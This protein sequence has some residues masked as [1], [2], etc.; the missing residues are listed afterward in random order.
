MARK[1]K[2]KTYAELVKISEQAVARKNAEYA[3]DPSMIERGTKE[4]LDSAIEEIANKVDVTN[5]TP[6]MFRLDNAASRAVIAGIGA[7]INSL[8]VTVTR[9]ADQANI[10]VEDPPVT[11][12]VDIDTIL[13]AINNSRGAEAAENYIKRLIEEDNARKNPPVSEE[14]KPAIRQLDLED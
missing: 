12:W 7:F 3:F 1:S 8:S 4:R 11:E 14:I 9:G 13:N 10:T 5:N 6:S 2:K